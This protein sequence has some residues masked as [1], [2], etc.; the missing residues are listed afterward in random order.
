MGGYAE[1]RIC[2]FEDMRIWGC[3]D[4]KICRFEVGQKFLN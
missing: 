4:V 3:E 1:V 2:R